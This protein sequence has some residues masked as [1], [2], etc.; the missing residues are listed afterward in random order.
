MTRPNEQGEMPGTMKS[1]FREKSRF[2][3]LLMDCCSFVGVALGAYDDIQPCATVALI[4]SDDSDGSISDDSEMVAGAS[5]FSRDVVKKE[6]TKNTNDTTTSITLNTISTLTMEKTPL[7]KRI[8]RSKAN[9]VGLPSNLAQNIGSGPGGNVVFDD[10]ESLSTL[11]IPPSLDTKT[12]EMPSPLETKKLSKTLLGPKLV[13]SK[14]EDTKQKDTKREEVPNRSNA[15]RQRNPYD[16]E[17]VPSLVDTSAKDDESVVSAM[18]AVDVETK[19]PIKKRLFR[20]KGK[21]LRPWSWKNNSNKKEEKETVGAKSPSI[22]R[23]S[24]DPT[25]ATD[26]KPSKADTKSSSPLSTTPKPTELSVPKSASPIP[27]SVPSPVR[28]HSPRHVLASSP[29]RLPQ[30]PTI[31]TFRSMVPVITITKSND[32]T[33]ST[34]GTEDE[35]RTDNIPFDEEPSCKANSPSRHQTTEKLRVSRYLRP[36]SKIDLKE[37]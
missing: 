23:A 7:V 10:S 4:D 29:P 31:E 16:I 20:G 17:R 27:R 21:M 32:I 11:K 12:V 13:E 15:S 24:F 8:L 5:V 30:K 28:R 37:F 18:S 34:V 25:P 22:W 6:T 33:A 9:G 14:V 36:S 19:E 2:E 1:S 26:A 35:E 3:F